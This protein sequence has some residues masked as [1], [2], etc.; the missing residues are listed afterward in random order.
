MLPLS[1]L[2]LGVLLQRIGERLPFRAK[3]F[4][5]I[6]LSLLA[7]LLPYRWESIARFGKMPAYNHLLVRG[8]V[9]GEAQGWFR[10]HFRPGMRAALLSEAR[11][12][13]SIPFPVVRL[14]DAPE[15][16][17]KLREAKSPGEFLRT[18]S[19]EG[20][21]QLILSDEKLDLFYP[22]DQVAAVE[23]YVLNRP[24]TFLFSSAHS[25]V[26]DL[27][28]LTEVPAQKTK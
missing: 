27:A 5:A 2:L 20:F 26:A 9:S 3:Y 16:D 12:Y 15:I 21:T 22:K 25:I 17:A 10:D 7:L 11:F 13:H 8:Y 6:L 23:A 18:L 4:P 19:A 1:A 24:E 14:W 28:K